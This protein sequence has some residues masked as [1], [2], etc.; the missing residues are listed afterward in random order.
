[1]TLA[2][3]SNHRI[4][5]IFLDDIRVRGILSGRI[6]A[7]VIWQGIDRFLFLLKVLRVITVFQKRPKSYYEETEVVHMCKFVCDLVAD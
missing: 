6:F 5:T 2:R 1:M 7:F 4:W 3:I